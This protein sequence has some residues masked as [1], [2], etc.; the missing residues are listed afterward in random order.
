MRNGRQYDDPGALGLSRRVLRWLRILNMAY[1]AGIGLML[2]VSIASPELLFGALGVR[3]AGWG[4]TTLAMRAIMLVGLAGAFIAHRILT[5]LLQIVDSVRDS[6]P[7]VLENAERLNAIAWWLL[8]AELLHLVVGVLASLASTPAQPI[9]IDW[10]FSFT[11][12]IAV[13]LLFVLARV[14][15]HGARMREDIEGTV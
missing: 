7:F 15:A 1:A 11:P 8:G 5:G 2:V 9:D 10:T 12:W 4:T 13:L 3:A 6:Q 14:F